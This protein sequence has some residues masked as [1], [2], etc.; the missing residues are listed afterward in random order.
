VSFEVSAA[1][2]GSF[3][4]RFSERLAP[5]FADAVGVRDGQRALDVGCGPGA[6]TGELA[7]RLGQASVAAVEPSSP[8]VAA[9]RER[10]PGVD[11]RQA[12]AESLPYAD[13]TFDV[14][15]AQ[16]VVHFMS[17]PVAGLREMGRVVRA[18][19]AVGACVWDHAG[20]SGPLAL[21]WDAVRVLDPGHAGE[22]D[23]PGTGPGQLAE[24]ALAAGLSDV[25]ESSLTVTVTMPTFDA[26]WAPFTL[27]VGPAG[28]YV[29]ALDAD[30]REELRRACR[31]VAPPEPFEV[32]ATAW[33]VRART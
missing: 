21:F 18:G 8:F 3:M 25:H 13:G 28:A 12:S 31:D 20:G 6:L 17:D 5:L 16:L 22:A 26:W 14:A 23:L 2:Y 33:C 32:R 11:V 15:L 27:G 1:A 9:A 10:F 30:R 7:A 19:G 24:L 4:G 29:A